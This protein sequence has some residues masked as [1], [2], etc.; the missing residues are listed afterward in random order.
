MRAAF[1]L[2]FVLLCAL[3]VAPDSAAHAP[4]L[5]DTL[6][7]GAPALAALPF[8]LMA[9]RNLTPLFEAPN[10]KGSGMSRADVEAIATD[11]VKRAAGP[12]DAPDLSAVARLL[13]DEKEKTAAARRDLLDAEAKIPAEDA[14]VLTGAE[15]TAYAALKGREGFEASPLAT[16]AETLDANATTLAEA[17]KLKTQAAQDAAFRKAGLDPEKVRTYIPALDAR[18]DGEGDASTAVAVLTAADGT[19]STQ[20]LDAYLQASHKEILPV[21]QGSGAAV[22]RGGEVVVQRQSGS[23]AVGDIVGDAIAAATGA[24]KA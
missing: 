7:V 3:A 14:V 6:T 4:T 15:A 11:A 22:A 13:A 23:A 9:P 24:D 10:D 5:A 16:A 1:A 20:P 19:V 17:A 12:G 21:L 8:G 18:L 2:C